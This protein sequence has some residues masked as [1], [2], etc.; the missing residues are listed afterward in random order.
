MTL[1]AAVI[2]VE[3]A[4]ADALSDALLAQGALATTIEDPLAG[5]PAELPVYDYS[6]FEAVVGWK[7][8]RIRALLSPE[9]DAAGLIGAAAR[10]ARLP[11]SPCF[12]LDTVPDEDWVGR[13]QAQFAPLRISDRLWIVPSWCRTPVPPEVSIALD[14]GLAFGT[15]SHPTTKACLQWL[16]R[17]V[18]A[19][20]Y[21][22]DYGCG[23][24]I[25]AIA[26]M[27]LGAGSAV[28]VDV[29]AGALEVARSNAAANA[30]HVGFVGA[31]EPLGVRAD[32]VV[33]NILA[34]PLK[35]LAPLLAARCVSSGRIALAGILE[36]QADEIIAAYRPWFDLAPFAV[37]DGWVTLEAMRR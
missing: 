3:A 7:R 34:G 35:M 23:S 37:E 15:G 11:A 28:G 14:P 2:E 26:A 6:G 25:L 21:V 16:E 33:A 32:L 5:T 8:A 10:A 4:E 22:L 9:D 36:R 30:V 18:F 1:R 13:I 17:H 20:A 31:N 19:G 27:K 12:A 29:D 24:G